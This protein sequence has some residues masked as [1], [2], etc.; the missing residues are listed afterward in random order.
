MSYIYFFTIIYHT[1]IYQSISYIY[2]LLIL[3]LLP[4]NLLNKVAPVCREYF[5]TSTD[6]LESNIINSAF[7]R[8]RVVVNENK[9]TR[10]VFNES[11]GT[12]VVINESSKNVQYLILHE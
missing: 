7:G 5:V 10:V 6:Y 3:I 1:I 2:A 9:G 12:R 8:T 4:E 11:K